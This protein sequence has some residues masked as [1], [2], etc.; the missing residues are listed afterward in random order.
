[1]KTILFL[2]VLLAAGCG[3]RGAVSQHRQHWEYKVVESTNVM[4]QGA[5]DAMMD[6]SLPFAQASEKSNYLQ[7]SSPDF[8]NPDFSALGADG[9]DLVGS[10]PITETKWPRVLGIEFE[11][12]IIQPN[13]STA[14]IVFIFKRPLD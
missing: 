1:M 13:I 14:K 10:Y 11:K 12:E 8:V 9:W 3:R 4:I 2:L 7:A 5:H 6:K